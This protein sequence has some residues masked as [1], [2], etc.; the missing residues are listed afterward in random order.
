MNKAEASSIF[1]E[2]IET[3]KGSVLVNNLSVDL[4]SSSVKNDEDYT[5]VIKGK[6]TT[7]ERMQVISVISKY[8]VIMKNEKECTVIYTP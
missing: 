3:C 2:I 6:L 1:Q 4:A 7:E 8:N 5:V